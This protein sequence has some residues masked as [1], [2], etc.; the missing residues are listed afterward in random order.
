M[1]FDELE[2]A[3]PAEILAREPFIPV[4]SFHLTCDADG[5]PL[6][7]YPLDELAEADRGLTPQEMRLL[8]RPRHH[9]GHGPF[10]HFSIN[11]SVGGP[12]TYLFLVEG[13]ITAI[14]YAENLAT[15]INTVYGHITAADCVEGA[16]RIT[17]CKFNAELTTAAY[18]DPVELWFRPGQDPN[19]A[20][21][22]YA[23]QHPPWPTRVPKAS[24]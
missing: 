21:R 18:S 10:S 5:L 1:D 11:P 15:E 19:F 24:Y 14:S 22:L 23:A 4:P 3:E 13:E 8:E 17:A 7:S 12:G 9:A 20:R 6:Q 2:S 16:A